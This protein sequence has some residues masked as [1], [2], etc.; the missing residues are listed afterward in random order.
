MNGEFCVAVHALI[1]LHRCGQITSSEELAHNICT[2]PARVRKVMSRLKKDG[3]IA[4]R[5]GGGDSG[6][7]FCG[8]PGTISLLRIMDALQARCVQARWHSGKLDM[9]CLAATG[10]IGL[11]D[12]ITEDLEACCRERLSGVTLEELERKL[13]SNQS[14]QE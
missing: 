11:M 10:M 3:L 8:D 1:Y 6:Y 13:F 14:N 4:A 7:R 5:A 9:D 12:G 2:N